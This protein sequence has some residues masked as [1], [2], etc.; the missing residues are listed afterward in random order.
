MPFA[1]KP[2]LLSKRNKPSLL[3]RRAVVKDAEEKK[4]THFINQ[5]N[6]VRN[7][8]AA[9]AKVKN[10]EKRAEYIK[11]KKAVEEMDVMK[12]K[13]RAKEYYKQEGQK[14]AREAASAGGRPAKKAKKQ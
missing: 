2:K 12:R 4:V 11:K 9:K 3:T 5:L 8:K 7:E 14:R 6:T 13:E 10:A 1:T